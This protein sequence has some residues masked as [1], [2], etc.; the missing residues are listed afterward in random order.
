MR[1]DAVCWKLV[2]YVQQDVNFLDSSIA[3][4]DIEHIKA[5]TS[6]LQGDVE[7]AVS[8]FLASIQLV[9][10]TGIRDYR[11]VKILVS[12][13]DLCMRSKQAAKA[14]EYYSRAV[15][16]MS[17]WCTSVGLQEMQVCSQ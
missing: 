15:K 9:E 6:L 1:H 10:D 14:G 2:D 13:G 16:L 11:T 5:S 17:T 4:A 8:N 3:K 12:C 7:L